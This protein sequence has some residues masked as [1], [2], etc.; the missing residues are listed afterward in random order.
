MLLIKKIQNGYV[1]TPPGLAA[2]DIY[3]RTLE[4][5]LDAARIFL[6]LINTSK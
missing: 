6:E 2:R 5:T 4:E 1:I 3:Y